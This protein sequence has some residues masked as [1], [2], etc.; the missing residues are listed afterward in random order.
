MLIKYIKIIEFYQE[1]KNDDQVQL[2]KTEFQT[3]KKLYKEMEFYVLFDF[4]K[5]FAQNNEIMRNILKEIR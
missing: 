1:N 2:A 3:V 5:E 4:E